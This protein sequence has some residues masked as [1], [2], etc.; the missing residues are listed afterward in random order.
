MKPGKLHILF[1]PAWYAPE[2]ESHLGSYIRYQAQIL[3]EQGIKT[4]LLFVGIATNN[5]LIKSET[6]HFSEWI[7]HIR[8]SSFK[9]WKQW[10]K[11]IR[12]QTL[13]REYCH[14][15]GRPT[16]IHTHSW[17]AIPYA[18]FLSKKYKIPIVHTEHLGQLL[19]PDS[20]AAKCAKKWI[21]RVTNCIA[22]SPAL[23]A[24][25]ETITGATP[26][27]IPNIVHSDF[28]EVP[29]NSRS[30]PLKTP[31][32]MICVSDFES[33]KGQLLLLH[34]LPYLDFCWQLTLV[35][36]GPNRAL[37]HQFVESNGL[38]DKVIFTGRLDRRQIIPL[39]SE[40][41]LYC[42]ATE[43][44][45]FGLHLAEALATG[46]PVVARHAF[47]PTLFLNTHNSVAIQELTP[48]SI[49]SAI[50][51]AF[52]KIDDFSAAEIR[53]G[54]LNISYPEVVIHRQIAY[55]QHCLN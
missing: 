32:R 6:G 33:N 18:R 24:S 37:L 5:N 39:L 48:Q 34:A 54:I 14:Q 13:F 8:R 42:T 20:T 30:E 44:E 41:H 15:Q 22:V 55:Y 43:Y 26:A 10:R 3:S 35:G 50:R 49:A 7:A 12:Y 38:M 16:I 47:G 25:L 31:L 23:A 45:S 46:L 40:S 1:L 2:Q 19:F 29:L 17:A 36:D 27:M 4:G 9:K 21:L 52:N 53:Q 11:I 28:F 51:S